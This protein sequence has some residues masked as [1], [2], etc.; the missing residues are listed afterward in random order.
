[1]EM[2]ST[3]KVPYKCNELALPEMSSADSHNCKLIWDTILCHDYLW[4]FIVHLIS[5]WTRW[6]RQH[7]SYNSGDKK[8]RYKVD[9]KQ[10]PRGFSLLVKCWLYKHED[11]LSVPRTHLIYVGVVTLTCYHSPGRQKYDP[12]RSMSGHPIVFCQTWARKRQY[13]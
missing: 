5:P 4:N 3:V 10:K 6:Q 1:M 2:S 8:Y 9:V 13:Q 12:Q 11:L 7:Y